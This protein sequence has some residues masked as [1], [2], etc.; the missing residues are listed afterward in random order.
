MELLTLRAGGGLQAH[1]GMP[2]EALEL[3]LDEHR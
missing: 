2:L 3:A 1:G